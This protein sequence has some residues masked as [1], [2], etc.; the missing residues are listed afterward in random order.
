MVKSPALKVPITSPFD[1][2]VEISGDVGNNYTCSDSVTFTYFPV[3]KPQPKESALLPE[4]YQ[5]TLELSEIL[6]E[7]SQMPSES[8]YVLDLGIEALNKG[9]L[10][11]RKLFLRAMCVPF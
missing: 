8:A 7:I 5:E 11:A 6:R 10:Q 4:T 9:T 3:E 2:N 1:V